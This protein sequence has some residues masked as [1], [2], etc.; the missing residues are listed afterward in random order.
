MEKENRVI[1]R[2]FLVFVWLEDFSPPGSGSIILLERCNVS[3]PEVFIL[4]RCCRNPSPWCQ[5]ESW[6][7]SIGNL[8]ILWNYLP[9]KGFFKSAAC[10]SI[11]ERKTNKLLNVRCRPI[12]MQGSILCTNC[13]LAPRCSQLT[14][15]LVLHHFPGLLKWD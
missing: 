4:S 2:P 14:F 15:K 1:E 7:V 12:K 6:I 13:T 8:L 3:K 11:A 9:G 10:I 5:K